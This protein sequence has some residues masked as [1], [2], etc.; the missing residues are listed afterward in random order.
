[1]A[2]EVAG[3]GANNYSAE[4]RRHISWRRPL[5]LA[6]TCHGRGSPWPRHASVD[7]LP[8]SPMRARWSVTSARPRSVGGRLRAPATYGVGGRRRAP[9][10]SPAEDGAGNAREWPS[11]N[12]VEWKREKEEKNVNW[13]VYR[14]SALRSMRRS[15]PCLKVLPSHVIDTYAPITLAP[16][17]V[18]LASIV[19]APT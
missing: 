16:I 9:A 3:A 10:A 4:G 5:S 11:S 8:R 15:L 2:S 18:R 17:C 7:P 6:V 19:R 13:L 12:R 14:W 1:M